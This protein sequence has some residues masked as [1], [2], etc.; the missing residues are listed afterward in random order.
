MIIADSVG[1]LKRPRLTAFV[2]KFVELVSPGTSHKRSLVNDGPVRH[3]YMCRDGVAA[4]AARAARASCW[5][6]RLERNDT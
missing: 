6:W 2:N 5:Y 4:A 1:E 3:A